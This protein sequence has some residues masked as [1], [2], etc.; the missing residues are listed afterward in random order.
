[1]IVD[2]TTSAPWT[3]ERFVSI[4]PSNTV[5]SFSV[6][7]RVSAPA[8]IAG[9][10]ILIHP[11]RTATGKW[12]SSVD[13]KVVHKCPCARMFPRVYSPAWQDRGKRLRR[14]NM[15]RQYQYLFTTLAEA[16]VRGLTSPYTPPLFYM[17]TPCVRIASFFST[18]RVCLSRT[19]ALGF[20]FFME[21][22]PLSGSFQSSLG[23]SATEFHHRLLRLR[24]YRSSAVLG[25]CFHRYAPI[26]SR[27]FR[28]LDST[29]IEVISFHRGRSMGRFIE[30][31]LVPLS[32]NEFSYVAAVSRRFFLIRMFLSRDISE[33]Y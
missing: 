15:T 26:S 27:L 2:S 33:R 18:Y 14:A 31:I 16:D 25:I 21:N 10:S 9:R 28:V 7:S 4:L 3:M 29:T 30:W 20:V 1:M 6:R 23:I 19:E 5:P 11:L 17:D 32:S 8:E 24:L 12:W 13:D 22:N